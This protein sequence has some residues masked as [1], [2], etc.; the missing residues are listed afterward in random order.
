[1]DIEIK[2]YLTTESGEALFGRGPA[3]LLENVD[4]LGSIRRAASLM[5]MSYSKAHER[6]RRLEKNLGKRFLERKIGGE[7][8]GGSS[9]TPYARKLLKEYRVLE[10]KIKD[11]AAKEFASFLKSLEEE[12]R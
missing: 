10:T 1:M 9:L 7:K 11:R 5:D 6:I 8:G 3:E 12:K 4:R 2:I